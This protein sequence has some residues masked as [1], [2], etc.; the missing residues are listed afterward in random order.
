MCD[1]DNIDVVV[2]VVVVVWYHCGTSSTK[3]TRRCF[4][5]IFARPWL[6]FSQAWNPVWPQLWVYI[7]SCLMK[8]ERE[9]G[10]VAYTI[11]YQVEV[12]INVLSWLPIY[13]CMYLCYYSL[14]WTRHKGK[15]WVKEERDC[16][17]VDI[18]SSRETKQS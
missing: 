9:R 8:R 2:A 18:F 12:R 3:D 6:Y 17:C 13:I 1:D 7:V 10:R 14:L 15:R 16:F 5:F 11:K 4:H